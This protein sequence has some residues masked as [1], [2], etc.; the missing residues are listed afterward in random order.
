VL[1]GGV[2]PVVAPVLGSQL[3][4]VTDWRGL[5]AALRYIALGSFVLERQYGLSAQAYGGLFA[6][7]ASSSPAA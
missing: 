4:R 7:M 1:V 2:A 6:V 5:F 3:L